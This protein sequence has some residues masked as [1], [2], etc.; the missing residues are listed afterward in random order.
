MTHKLRTHAITITMMTIENGDRR[1]LKMKRDCTFAR[2][3]SSMSLLLC[4]S[5]SA[6]QAACTVRR[7]TALAALK[8]SSYALRYNVRFSGAAESSTASEGALEINRKCLADPT[9]AFVFYTA[10][11]KRPK[12]NTNLETQHTNQRAPVDLNPKS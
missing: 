12:R 1:L 5:A 11:P 10:K 8:Q 6:P 3:I 2:T 4:S 7:G 9:T